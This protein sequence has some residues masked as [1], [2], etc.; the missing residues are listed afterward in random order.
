MI[1]FIDNIII[2]GDTG[3][4]A[5]M[6]VKWKTFISFT[7]DVIQELNNLE[8]ILTKYNSFFSVSLLVKPLIAIRFVNECVQVLCKLKNKFLIDECRKLI[9]NLDT[10]KETIIEEV[11]QIDLTPTLALALGIPIPF[12][13]LGIPIMNFFKEGKLDALRTNLEQVIFCKIIN[14]F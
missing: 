2:N 5:Q 11:R 13:N 10:F 7:N 1:N 4:D 8:S 14:K 6:I 9:I 12:S 3:W